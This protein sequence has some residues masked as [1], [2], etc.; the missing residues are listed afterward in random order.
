MRVSAYKLAAYASA[1]HIGRRS[2]LIMAGLVVGLFGSAGLLL[3][4]GDLDFGGR[5]EILQTIPYTPGRI[6]FEIQR[7][8]NQALNGPRYAVL[9]EDH[10]PTTLEMKHAMISFWRHRSF[11]LANQSIVMNWLGPNALTLTTTAAGTKPEWVLRQRRQIGDVAI[12]YSG[13]P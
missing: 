6:A 1:M 12:E 7:T 8:D 11:R 4:D 10:T 5:Y 3:F 2:G 13:Q 9:I